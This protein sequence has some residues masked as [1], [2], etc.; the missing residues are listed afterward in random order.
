[1]SVTPTP[2]AI[3]II[4]EEHQALGAMLSSL[5]LLL[6][7]HRQDGTPVRFDVLRAMLFYIDEFPERLHHR[8]ESDLLF[9]MLRSRSDAAAE[10]LDKLDRDHAVG[11]RAIRDLEHTLLAWEMLGETRRED[12]TQAVERYLSFYLKHMQLEEE[13]VLPLAQQVLE[14][15]DWAVLDAAFGENRDPLTGHPPSAEYEQLF[16]RIVR[17]APAPIGLG[18]AA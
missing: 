17:T 12:F 13:I 11:E 2:T 18:G 9:P 7:Q 6:R 8:K 16:S 15:A 5:H 14:P 10:V 1:M 4:R 3:R